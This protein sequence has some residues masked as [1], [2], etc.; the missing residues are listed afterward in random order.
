MRSSFS[1]KEWESIEAFALIMISNTNHYL[2]NIFSAYLSAYAHADYISHAPELVA[3]II[4]TQLSRMEKRLEGSQDRADAL[5]MAFLSF[6]AVDFGLDSQI[7]NERFVLMPAIYKG[8]S[9]EAFAEFVQRLENASGA[10]AFRNM[11]H[12]DLLQ[13]HNLFE[14]VLEEVFK[15]D[16]C[17]FSLTEKEICERV[18]LALSAEESI[19][20][21]Q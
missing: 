11:N 10:A 12:T 13:Q 7:V 15:K 6:L 1:I 8:T 2:R 3:E 17:F 19:T 16:V 21:N 4:I 14:G 20:I 5:M 18:E 9:A